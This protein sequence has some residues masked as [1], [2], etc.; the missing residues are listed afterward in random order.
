MT[1]PPNLV[2]RFRAARR[3]PALV[4]LEGLHALKHALRFGA[5]IE[6]VAT[7]DP[8]A[9]A[10]LAHDLAPDV[11]A[12]IAGLAE[13]C[14][15]AMFAQ[16]APVVPTTGVVALARRPGVEARAV[17]RPSPRPVVV[18]EAP[19]HLGNVGAAV[20]VAAAADAAGLVVVG[21]VD[22]YHP[23]VVRGAAGLQFALPCLRLDALPTT[24]RPL[25]ALDACGTPLDE[26][27]LPAG[28]VFAFGTERGGLSRELR[29]RAEH[30]VAIPMRAGV[31]SLNLATA[32]AV[33][34]Y[35]PAARGNLAP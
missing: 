3:D 35:H 23:T 13:T 24:A 30:V 17:L 31:S 6:A 5:V 8:A 7:P 12:E 26:A 18:L 9:L 4:V 27:L 16:L 14:G 28:A 2:A 32:V 20:R 34:L 21:Q 1:P 11:A 33:L 10:E 29:G 22:P 15:A 25:V 19:Q